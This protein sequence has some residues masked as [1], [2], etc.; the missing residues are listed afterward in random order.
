M[1]LCSEIRRC[2]AEGPCTS[3]EIA[4][5]SGLSRRT[6]HVRLG[7]L[8]DAGHI[9]KTGRTIAVEDS[10]KPLILWELAAA[11]RIK[12]RRENA[13]SERILPPGGDVASMP[14]GSAGSGELGRS[15]V[16][17]PG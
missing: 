17:L 7:M 3:R 15:D 10:R 12:L 1:N 2:L 4:A 16:L 8:R 9:R 5:I 6:V 11:G 13:T 14:V